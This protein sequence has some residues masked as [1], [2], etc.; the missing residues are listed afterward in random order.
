MKSLAWLSLTIAVSLGRAVTAD[1]QI[2][3]TAMPIEPSSAVSQGTRTSAARLNAHVMAGLASWDFGNGDPA[4]GETLTGGRN[5]LIIA[6]DL[7]VRA[8][9]KLVVGAGGWFNSVEQSVSNQGTT[10]FTIDRTAYSIYGNL[11]WGHVGVQAGVVPFHD[12]EAVSLL[13][14]GQRYAGDETVTEN[15][16]DVFALGRFGSDSN[17]RRWSAMLGAGLYRYG[18][19]PENAGL[20][21][22][23][24]SPSANVFSGFG[25][26]SVAMYRRLSVDASL[27]YTADDGNPGAEG[28]VSQLRFTIGVGLT[29]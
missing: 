22:Q 15:D 4:P 2:I 7:A 12:H 29:I 24:A 3:S 10:Q 5:G 1:A 18:S 9:A 11:F 17:Q 28:N 27:W 25:T 14:N 6:G 13:M 21:I 23:P 16:V 19:R 26:A 20:F 8:G